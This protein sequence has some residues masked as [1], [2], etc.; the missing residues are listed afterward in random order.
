MEI[1]L[2]VK[3][4]IIVGGILGLAFLSQQPFFSSNSKNFAYSNGLTAAISKNVA[5]AQDWFND[6][7]SSKIG[8]AANGGVEAASDTLDSAKQEIETQ[9]NNLAKNSMDSKKKLIAQNILKLLG[10]TPEEIAACPAD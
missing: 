10:V 7:V 1:R 5:G 3:N 9:K 2:I 4:T 6:N 8:G